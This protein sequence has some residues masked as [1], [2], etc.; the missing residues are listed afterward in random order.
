MET[1]YALC[2]RDPSRSRIR[3]RKSILSF[4]VDFLLSTFSTESHGSLS[5][6]RCLKSYT[7]YYVYTYNLPEM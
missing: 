6:A 5:L 7:V 4:Y 2:R 1:W 3:P